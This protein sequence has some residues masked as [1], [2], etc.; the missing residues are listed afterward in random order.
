[1]KRDEPRAIAEIIESLRKSNELGK[2][3]HLAKIWKNW[4][5]MAGMKL[6]PRGRP[7]GV[8]DKTL[9]VEVE[10]SVW[11]HHYSYHEHSILKR[12]N[13]LLN[14]NLLED[15]FLVLSEEEISD[16]SEIEDEKDA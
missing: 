3:F 11:L 14:E 7:L 1:M 2:Q 10:S 8:R 12:I 13:N 16:P 15:I 4:P 9:I 6:M 5:E